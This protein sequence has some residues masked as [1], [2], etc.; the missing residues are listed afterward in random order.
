MAGFNTNS[1]IK[2]FQDSSAKVKISK[3][4][5]FALNG[6]Y[7]EVIEKD[8]VNVFLVRDPANVFTSF[9]PTS[10]KYFHA[11]AKGTHKDLTVYYGAVL[12][13]VEKVALMC[14]VPPMIVDG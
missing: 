8:S 1:A 10:N 7:E 3:D 4:F 9:L 2:Q 13:G 12:Q 11:V 5:I 14:S 6:R